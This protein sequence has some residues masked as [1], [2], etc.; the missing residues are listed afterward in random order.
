MKQFLYLILITILPVFELRGSI[1]L[2]ILQYK[3]SRFNVISICTIANIAIAPI[4]Y[5][6]IY[7]A[8]RLICRSERLSNMYQRYQNAV[9]NRLR[10]KIEKWG[11][12]GLALF[13]GIPLPGSGVYS[14]AI[15]AH[16]LGIS[17]KRYLGA[18]FVGVIM[19]STIVSIITIG[20]FESFAFFLNKTIP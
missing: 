9:I 15:G 18:S 6:L 11:F 12:W 19:A 4:V 14:G 17:F 2:G 5:Y 1:P 8:I 10:P 13:I 7:Y 3:L 16:A 20:G